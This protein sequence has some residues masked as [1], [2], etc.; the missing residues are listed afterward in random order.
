MDT[1]AAQGIIEEET[2]PKGMPRLTSAASDED[3]D[4]RIRGYSEV[5]HHSAGTA[6]MGQNIQDS[7][8]DAELNVHGLKNLRVVDASVF[9]EPISATPQATVYAI[10]ELAAVLI[11]RSMGQS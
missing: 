10:A 7:V 2:T 6:A 11:S 4:A 8:V 9:P 1:A 5:W 3:I